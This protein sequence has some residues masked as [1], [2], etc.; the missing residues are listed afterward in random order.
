[1]KPKYWLIFAL[2]IAGCLL[3]SA[4]TG[5]GSKGWSGPVVVEEVGEEGSYDVLY[6]G[7]REGKVFRLDLYSDPKPHVGNPQWYPERGEPGL[8]GNAGGGFLSCAPALAE[9]IYSTPAVAD[10][11]VYIGTYGGEVY[12]IDA[13]TMREKW[14]YPR[15]GDVGRIVGSPVVAVSYTHLTLPTTPYV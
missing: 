4:C 3:L 15:S 8:G 5:V 7:T 11:T 9:G 10:G 2:L 12:A 1:M 13:Y 14:Q 6:I